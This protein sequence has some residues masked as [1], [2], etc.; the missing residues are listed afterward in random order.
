MSIVNV[1][2]HTAPSV[3][4]LEAMV[5]TAGHD[6]LLTMFGFPKVPL[7]HQHAEVKLFIN[8]AEVDFIKTAQ[9]MWD[10][11]TRTYNEDLEEAA[12]KLVKRTRLEKLEEILSRA[13][14][15]VESEVNKLLQEEQN[16]Q[17]TS[18]A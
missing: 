5:R 6:Q 17:R 11:M 8:G 1:I 9:E 7:T 15:L 3:M 4:I 13:E 14:E 2:D 16:E 18:N 10:R 12:R